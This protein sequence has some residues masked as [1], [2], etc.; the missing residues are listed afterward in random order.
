M[1]NYLIIGF[2]K[3]GSHLHNAIKCSI[4]DSN[5]IISKNPHKKISANVITGSDVIFIC[6]QDDKIHNAV[7]DI[8]KTKTEISGKIF[9][10]TSGALSSDELY[11]L[12]ANGA[13]TSS[14]HPVQTFM[15]KAAKR[16]NLFKNI[17]IAIEGDRKAVK[18]LS[19]LAKKMNASPF[20]IEKK[21]KIL[22]HLC[23]VISSNYLVTNLSLLEDIYAKK[24]GFKKVNFFNI[25]MPLIKQTLRNIETSGIKSALTGPVV[26]KDYNTIGKHIDALGKFKLSEII[27]YYKFMGIETLK[28]AKRK[29]SFNKEDLLKIQKIFRIK[30]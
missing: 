2:G 25:Y 27:D 1:K 8:L 3:V 7:K 21:F 15:Q 6:S 30:N 20:K 14:F 9:A 26:R 28:I 29:E 22:H 13:L 10:H 18:E 23:C 11:K 4:K 12:K 17:Y 16:N 5:V 19:G 24:N